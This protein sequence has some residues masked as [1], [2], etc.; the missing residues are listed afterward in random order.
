MSSFSLGLNQ[1]W[2]LLRWLKEIQKPN[3]GT[4]PNLTIMLFAFYGTKAITFFIYRVNW[5]CQKR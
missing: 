2:C 1:V 5:Y 4:Q 3:S